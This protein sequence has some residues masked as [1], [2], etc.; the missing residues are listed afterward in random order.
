MRTNVRAA[1]WA[2]AAAAIFLL[3]ARPARAEFPDPPLALPESGPTR[4]AV[5]AGGCFWGV[6]GV[7]EKLKGV[8]EAVSG[9]SGGARETAQYDIVST[10][11]TGHAES[12]QVTYDPSQIG[13]GT[14]LKVFFSVAH[15]PTELNYQGPDH[16]TQYRSAIFYSGEEQRRMAEAYIRALDQAKVYGKS[17]VTQLVPLKAFYPAEDYH[18]DFMKK[19]PGYPYIVVWDL[20]KIAKLEKEYPKLVN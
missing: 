19:N 9:Y 18:Q 8:K 16:G 3:A 1:V 4:T 5:F 2:C 10:G 6:E 15:D 14:L 7:F 13:Y 17:I 12:V 20:P 11:T